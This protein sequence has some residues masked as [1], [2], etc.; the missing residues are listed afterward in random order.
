LFQVTA[1]HLWKEMR[2]R[3]PKLHKL[4]HWEYRRKLEKK[5][6][7]A[8]ITTTIDWM[9]WG[10][11]AAPHPYTTEWRVDDHT[12][13]ARP[14]TKLHPHYMTPE[15]PISDWLTGG[16]ESCCLTS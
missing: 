16:H 7:E 13:L 6:L 5:Q 9:R 15:P 4:F 10:V 2:K 1:D 3:E 11:R 8:R 12:V 14:P